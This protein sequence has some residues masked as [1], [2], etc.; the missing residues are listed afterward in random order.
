MSS[1]SN[2]P[3]GG[4]FFAL[5]AWVSTVIPVA[6]VISAILTLS[7]AAP[8]MIRQWTS[9]LDAPGKGGHWL[10]GLFTLACAMGLLAGAVSLFGVRRNRRPLIVLAAVLGLLLNLVVGFVASILWAISDLGIP[11]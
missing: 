2:S 1:E 8:V 7:T 3:P 4:L 6:V 5:A 11:S 10:T 9:G